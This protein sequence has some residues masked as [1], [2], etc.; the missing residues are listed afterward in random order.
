MI[1][2]AFTRPQRRL[3]ESVEMA[4]RMGFRVLAAPS[5]DIVHGDFRD[6]EE[7]EKA[8][9]GDRYRTVIFSSATAV[10]ECSSEWKD[11]FPG[12][13]AGKEVIAIGTG[14]MRKLEGM[15]IAVASLPSE[16]TSSGLV[17]LLKDRK[18]KK[19]IMIIHSD[20][21]SDILRSGLEESGYDVGELIAYRLEEH[22]GGL[23]SIR[24]A[25]EK[26][27]VDV[28]AFTSRM[29]VD[30]FLDSIGISIDK[31]F[32]K[33]KVAAIGPPT[34]ERLEEKGIGVDIMPKDATFKTLLET[35]KEVFK[36]EQ[37]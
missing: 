33:S 2:L 25:A 27:E 12:L 26:G 16:F 32:S 6:Y 31:L 7:T 35:I 11:T 15:G 17:D 4:E 5:L 24:S 29:S 34:K 1:T 14:T 20:H 18:E 36:E 13:M 21:G 30:S 3:Q 28:F 19:G 10:E 23:D 9:S 8:L 22:E 37:E